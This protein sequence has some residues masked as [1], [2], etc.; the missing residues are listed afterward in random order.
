MKSNQVTMAFVMNYGAIKEI[1]Y[2]YLAKQ[3][4]V[5]EDINAKRALTRMAFYMSDLFHRDV[6]KGRLKERY[7]REFGETL[8]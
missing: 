5:C 2:M 7:R 3:G 4:E 1:I 6:N 8:I